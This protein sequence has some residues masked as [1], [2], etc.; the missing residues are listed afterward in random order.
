MPCGNILP[1]PPPP[2]SELPLLDLLNQ[3]PCPVVITDL[4]GRVL[5][6]N[7]NLAEL[8]GTEAEQFLHNSI[9][10][11]FPPASRIFLQ[12]HVWPMLIREQSVR[13]IRLQL[14]NSSNH[15]IPV[16]VN[17]Q[18]GQHESADC[19][20]WIF[21]VTL[22]RNR[23][24]TEL[25]NARN[26]AEESTKALGDS[27]RFIK[28]ITNAMPAM[29]AYWDKDLRCRFANQSYLARF[30]KTDKEII[31]NTMQ[32][33]QG[34]A[35]FTVSDPHIQGVMEG[36]QQNFESTLNK[37]DGS[38]GYVWAIYAPDFDN[39]GKFA[40]FYVLLT[41]ITPLTKARA[42]L[43][44]AHNVFQNIA[45]GIMVTDSA[46][47]IVSVNP[48]F[49]DIT[50]YNTEDVVGQRSTMLL[51]ARL[52][53][54]YPA[55][56]WESVIHHGTWQ[57]EV[58]ECRKN[59]EEYPSW[60]SITSVKNMDG[61]VANYVTM[62]SDITERKIIDNM[63]NEFVSTVSH[64]LRTPL[65]S[66]LGALSLLSGGVLGE[67]SEQAK[68]MIN[69]AH[70]NS[71][72]LLSLINDLLDMDKMLA[73]KLILD[74]QVQPLMPLVTQTLESIKSYGDQ[75]SVSFKLISEEDV[76]VRVD[77]NRLIQV[78]NNFLSNA[79]KFSAHGGQVEIAVRHINK[80]IRIEVI[81]HGAGIPE[82]FKDHIFKKF[83]QADSSTTRQKGG[84]GLGLAISKELV[85]R[86]HGVVG[87]DSTE[88]Q[89]ACFYLELP[90]YTQ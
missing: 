62:L 78:L 8:L 44:L 20:Y 10:G 2:I 22:E 31:G 70:K 51:P 30:D 14:R 65:T 54:R 76:V 84:T 90:L 67:M 88:G 13:E 43:K 86:M 21:F 73:G 25:V 55:E 48:A 81:D 19:Y 58:L 42:E 9:N 26:R 3:L 63:K 89:G 24:E 4:T 17:C 38:V 36:K 5:A 57:G 87:F 49:T 23:F 7:S 47:G 41:D 6:A 32:E 15:N 82:K 50:G 79:A 68:Q 39:D 28:N 61:T 45:Q 69:L 46:G 35:L 12:T 53:A 77:S 59:G 27:E 29:V 16:L 40:G 66:I 72:R 52:N 1:N 11:L 71:Q 75:Y 80:L 37:A 74:L 83:S 85:E 18:K 34:E 33:L 64:E 56:I 60:L